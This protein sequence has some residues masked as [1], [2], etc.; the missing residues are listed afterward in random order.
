MPAAPYQT[1]RLR[2]SFEHAPWSP[3]LIPS[4]KAGPVVYEAVEPEKAE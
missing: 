4:R 1:R 3:A 2:D